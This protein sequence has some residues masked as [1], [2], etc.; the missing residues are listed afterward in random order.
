M[1]LKFDGTIG[2]GGILGG[3]FNLGSSLLNNAYQTKNMREQMRWQEKMNAQQQEWQESM[4]NKTNE[5]NTPQA[6]M[7]RLMEA[8]VN[9]NNAAQMIAGGNNQADL[10]QQPTTPTAPNGFSPNFDLGRN[11]VEMNLMKKQADVLESQAN[12]NNAEAEAASENV[13]ISKSG[14]T[15]N[16]RQLDIVQNRLDMDKE[17][18]EHDLKLI[19]N[20]AAREEAMAAYQEWYNRVMLPIIEKQEWQ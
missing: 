8:G 15:L 5:Y 16:A 12:K 4:W 11:F 3:L 9:P 6:Q 14:L 13:E 17:R 18:Q 19:D 2:A 10:A 20:E 1:A 7:Q